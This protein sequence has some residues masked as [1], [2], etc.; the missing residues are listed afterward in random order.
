MLGAVAEVS[1][2]GVYQEPRGVTGGGVPVI[3]CRRG[4]APGCRI[5]IYIYIYVCVYIYIYI[6]VHMYTYY[7]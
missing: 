1:V 2:N 3:G 4:F 7:M 5:Y 6:Y